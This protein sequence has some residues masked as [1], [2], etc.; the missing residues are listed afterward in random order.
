MQTDRSS[1]KSV[2]LKFKAILHD[3][4]GLHARDIHGE[5]TTEIH[6][7]AKRWYGWVEADDGNQLQPSDYTLTLPNGSLGIIMVTGNEF[8]GSL[9]ALFEGQ[10]KNPFVPP[11]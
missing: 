4:D 8:P 10:G 2:F 1:G 3:L 11:G 7:P 9:S 5:W 6:P